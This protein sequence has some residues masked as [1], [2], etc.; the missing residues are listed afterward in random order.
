[1]VVVKPT[2]WRLHSLEVVLHLAQLRHDLHGVAGARC[3]EDLRVL[4]ESVNLAQAHG[5][6]SGFLGWITHADPHEHI[7][8]L[9]VHAYDQPRITDANNC[10]DRRSVT[11]SSPM[12]NLP[13]VSR[14][15]SAKSCSFLMA[16]FC[17]TDTPNWTLAFVYSCPGWAQY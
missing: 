3:L 13:C 2:C 4:P 12:V 6:P 14:L 8:L 1:M 17:S 16:S 7:V 10:L 15:F 11:F 5:S 9:S